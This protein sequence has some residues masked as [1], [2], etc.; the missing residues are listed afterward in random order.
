MAKRLGQVR[1][2]SIGLKVKRVVGQKRVILSELKTG[3]SQL[4]CESGQVGLG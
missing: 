2:E 1:V 4:G 3:S